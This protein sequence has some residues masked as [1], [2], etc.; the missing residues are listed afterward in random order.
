MQETLTAAPKPVSAEDMVVTK[1]RVID[2]I[3][4]VYDPEI[5]VNVYDMGLIYNIEI[6]PP[7]QV[8]ITM[9]LT[10]PSCPSAMTLPSEVETMVCSL[11]EVGNAT[12]EIT[13]DP[14]YT[15]D[16]MDD[17]AKLELGFL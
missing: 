6:T 14:P 16:M 2:A 17:A 10:T 1:E 9:T 5:P 3:R 15:I 12:V 7:D 13:F 11:P 8:L 4:M